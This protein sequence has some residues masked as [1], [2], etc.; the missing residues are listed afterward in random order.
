VFLPEKRVL[1]EAVGS[2]NHVLYKRREDIEVCNAKIS[3]LKEEMIRAIRNGED[4][5]EIT[6]QHVQQV[7]ILAEHQN[8]IEKIERNETKRSVKYCKQRVSWVLQRY[9]EEG[10]HKCANLG[11]V[12]AKQRLEALAPR[13]QVDK[14]P[15]VF[16]SSKHSVTKEGKVITAKKDG[17]STLRFTPAVKSGVLKFKVKV[18]R[19]DPL[20]GIGCVPT[21]AENLKTKG[22]YDIGYAYWDDGEK[23]AL[24]GDEED[25]GAKYGTGDVIEV[26]I[27]MDAR[28][29]SFA[30]NGESQG[31]AVENLPAEGVY[32]AI[33]IYLE[34]ESVEIL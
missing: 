9:I 22:L 32:P 10:D 21:T 12:D 5:A 30:T 25:Y 16:D 23:N 27:D 2:F 7:T 8:H 26:T 1:T 20:I 24:R 28:T 14:S 4:I 11:L 15:D 17:W 34:N 33:D 3:A 31:V 13:L 29:L 19:E 6:R 18:L